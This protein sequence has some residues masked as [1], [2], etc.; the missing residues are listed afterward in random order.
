MGPGYFVLALLGC[1]D[2]A[3]TCTEARVL[4]V[5]YDSVAEC[6]AATSTQ[7]PANSDL[8]FPVIMGRCKPAS[9]QMAD[10]KSRKSPS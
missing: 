5:R 7:L 4:N 2:A 10:R 1:D 6:L 3:V 9:V 8:S